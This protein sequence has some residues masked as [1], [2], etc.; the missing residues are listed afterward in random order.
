MFI[1]AF[2][3]SAAKVLQEASSAEL[4]HTQLCSSRG[5]YYLASG[6]INLSIHLLMMRSFWVQMFMFFLIRRS[7]G[8]RMYMYGWIVYTLG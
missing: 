7:H 4:A 1:S 6:G 3:L 5:G 8:G 2:V